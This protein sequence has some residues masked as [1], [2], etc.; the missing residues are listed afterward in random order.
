M[1]NPDFISTIQANRF[2]KNVVNAPTQPSTTNEKITLRF[3]DGSTST[4]AR[5]RLDN[6]FVQ[7]AVNR[8]NAKKSATSAKSQT[9]ASHL[10]VSTKEGTEDTKGKRLSRPTTLLFSHLHHKD[11]NTII[12]PDDMK[13]KCQIYATYDVI[14]RPA[15]TIND[16][17]VLGLSVKQQHATRVTH[18]EY[19]YDGNVL[20]IIHDVPTTSQN[21]VY[22][23][24]DNDVRRWI[25]SGA[26]CNT[27]SVDILTQKMKTLKQRLL[28]IEKEMKRLPPAPAPGRGK[29]TAAAAG[30]FGSSSL[31]SM[32]R[33]SKSLRDEMERTN[34]L[35]RTTTQSLDAIY[36][37]HVKDCTLSVEKREGSKDFANNDNETCDW[38]VQVISENEET[39]EMYTKLIGKNKNW[40]TIPMYA[41]SSKRDKALV[42]LATPD[43]ENRS[44]H[45][46]EIGGVTITKVPHGF[47]V[48]ESYEEFLS[49]DKTTKSR[50]SLFH[51]HFRDGEFSEGTLYT[52]TGVYSGKFVSNQPS[53]GTMEYADGVKISGHFASSETKTNFNNPYF[54]RLPH[55]DDVN[56]KFPDKAT[57]NGRMSDGLIDGEGV[58]KHEGHELRGTFKNGGLQDENGSEEEGQ[59]NASLSTRSFMYDRERLWVS[60]TNSPAKK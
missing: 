2:K 20:F 18:S 15:I 42:L 11:S 26:S 7:S 50:H 21:G 22:E 57:Y 40:S 39:T 29:V 33:K 49:S 27:E 53:I 51:G 9:S 55:G 14:S 1:S 12:M 30:G 17:G 8:V 37:Q 52:E 13:E 58:Y 31:Q 44:D 25:V 23:V 41:S 60:N 6:D 45:F 10:L 19:N 48:L 54:R 43:E 24:T 47:G 34:T 3:D 28:Q 32:E 46:V 36:A 38:T 5:F 4:V 56:I 59:G 16:G 35:L